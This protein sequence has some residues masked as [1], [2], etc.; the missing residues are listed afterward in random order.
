MIIALK[1]IKTSPVITICNNNK[2][3]FYVTLPL[4]DAHKIENKSLLLTTICSTGYI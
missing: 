1:S 4:N 3:I 2:I